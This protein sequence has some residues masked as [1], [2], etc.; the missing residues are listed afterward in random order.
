MRAMDEPAAP[1]SSR[2]ESS[3]ESE[4]EIARAL[5]A[6]RALVTSREPFDPYRLD[7]R[8]PEL[9]RVLLPFFDLLNRRYLG[10]RVSGLEHLDGGQALFVGNH[11]GGI[12]GPDLSCT[13]ATLWRHVPDRPLYAMAHDFAMRHVTPLG[14]FLQAVGGMRADPANATQVLA[15][16]GNVLVYPGGDLEAFRHFRHRDRIVFG[17]R[18][19]FVKVAQRA[20][21]PIVPIVAHG[22]HKSSIIVHEGEWLARVLGLTARARLQ[23]FPVAIG[24]PWVLGVGPWVPFLP[25]PFRI[26]LRVLAPIATSADRDSVEIRD[27]VT[28]SMQRA[29]DEMAKERR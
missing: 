26:R 5:A 25:L 13:L 19:G 2:A 10:L 16:G 18:T 3:R 11:N 9:V 21:V 8:D 6:V 12:M 20:G 15:A 27:E 4:L 14:R 17:P 7:R 1:A 23:R 24:F 22:A 29:L 28:G